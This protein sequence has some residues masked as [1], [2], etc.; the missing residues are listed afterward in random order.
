VR[1]GPPS[2][3]GAPPERP[4]P[5]TFAPAAALFLALASLAQTA[6]PSC[7]SA[8]ISSEWLGGWPGI[9]EDSACADDGTP[10]SEPPPDIRRNIIEH[11]LT[12]QVCPT[13]LVFIT[14]EYPENT[15]SLA[16]D[17]RL[18]DAA[19]GRFSEARK[20]AL[21]LSC[22]DLIDGCGG[23]CLPAGVESRY[24]LHQSAPWTLSS[25]RVDRFIGNFRSGRHERGTVSYAFENFSLAT[26]KELAADEIF[27][28]PRAAAKLFWARADEVLKSRGACPSRSY[29]V[30]GRPAGRD[31]KASDVLLSRRG[32]TLALYTGADK[33]CVPQALDLPLEEMIALGASPGLWTDLNPA[34][35]DQDRDQ[36][37]FRPG[38]R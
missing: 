32:A 8:W 26:G 37:G 13:D 33:K 11:Q 1:P 38:S 21:K 20:L 3:A 23:L 18:A 4:A 9:C 31:L 15:G 25:F 22:N 5:K 36:G 24:Y 10:L 7:A 12:S 30:S 28:D 16:L 29:R 19:A 17:V 2:A 27:P 34:D 6:A 14:I 35:P